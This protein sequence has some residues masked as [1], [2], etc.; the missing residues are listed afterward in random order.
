[1]SY[2]CAIS[3]A[4]LSRPTAHLI[5]FFYIFLLGLLCITYC[6]RLPCKPLV[7]VIIVSGITYELWT[8]NYQQPVHRLHIIRRGTIIATII[9]LNG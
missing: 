5:V 6:V 2:P 7:D 4:G 3:I 8:M 9:P 1:M